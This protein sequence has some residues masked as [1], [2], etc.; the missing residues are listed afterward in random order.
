[1]I[2]NPSYHYM[3]L[4]TGWVCIAV[5]GDFRF[6]FVFVFFINSVQVIQHINASVIIFLLV[7]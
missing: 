6:F 2:V 5:S 1:M 3:R 4:T 7:C